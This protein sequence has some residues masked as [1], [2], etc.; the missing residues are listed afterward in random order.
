[1]YLNLRIH[2]HT[3]S[4]TTTTRVKTMVFLF[5]LVVVLDCWLCMFLLVRYRH[6]FC[7]QPTRQ[8]NLWRRK[9]FS[10]NDGSVDQSPHYSRG[11]HPGPEEKKADYMRELSV[12]FIIH[13]V[14]T[15]LLHYIPN[16]QTKRPARCFNVIKL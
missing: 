16:K 2:I 7:P 13:R 10:L 5:C 15:Y 6:F 14:F 9:N 11:G 4:F 8:L 3:L 1:M 12:V